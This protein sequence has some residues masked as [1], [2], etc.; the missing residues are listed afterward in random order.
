MATAPAPVRHGERL[1]PPC[2]RCQASNPFDRTLC[3]RC[4]AVLTIRSAADR[5]QQLPWWRRVFRRD[6]DRS[7]TV[8]SRPG[9]RRRRPRLLLPLIL[10][11]LLL[12]GWLAREQIA[13]GF[14]AL[15]DRISDPE[16]LR[17]LEVGASSEHKDHPASAAFDGFHNRYWAPKVPG[18][19]SGEHLEALFENPVRLH[20]LLVIPGS[21]VNQD[22]FLSQARPAA[23][24]VTLVDAE[25]DRTDH[26]IVLRDEPGQ[27]TFEV[28]G[29]DIIGV[30]LTVDEAHGTAP[31]R[32]V[33]VAE[34][35]F[36]GRR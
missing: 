6:A 29:R 13:D 18:P 22:E 14:A 12:A 19:G 34:V 11:L 3:R 20:T 27:Q 24:T 4:G 16:A 10:V 26:R 32:H 25:G 33:A 1:A 7:L 28:S 21:S 17:P 15:R 5:H 30:R 2:P 8:G 31:D 36:F 9:Q 23:L 35:E